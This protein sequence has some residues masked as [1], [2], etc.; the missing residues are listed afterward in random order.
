MPH[1]ILE[2][3]DV[4]KTHVRNST[5]WSPIAISLSAVYYYNIRDKESFFEYHEVIILV[6]A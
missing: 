5:P 4:N 2:G 1:K 3:S 6:G